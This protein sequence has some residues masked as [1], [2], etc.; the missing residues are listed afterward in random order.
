MRLCFPAFL[1]ISTFSTAKAQTAH[2]IPEGWKEIHN[3]AHIRLDLRY[4][5]TQNF[6]GEKIYACGRCFLKSE[7][8]AALQRAASILA[9]Q[10][11]GLILFDCYRPRPAQWKLWHIVPDPRYVA[12]PREGSMHNRGLAVDLSL[13][14]LS[15]GQEVAMGTAY[16]FFGPAAHADYQALPKAVL[17]ARRILREAMQQAGFEGIRTEWW[18]FSLRDTSAPLAEWE[19]GCP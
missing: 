4:A 16:D 8:A 12:D 14:D 19:W 9:E 17:R 1:L 6:T 11:Y 3:S 7:A 5:S 15:T 13:F 2:A 18:H 10:G